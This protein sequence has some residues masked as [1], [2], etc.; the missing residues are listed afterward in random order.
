MKL[1]IQLE[2]FNGVKFD[3]IELEVQTTEDIK[4]AYEMLEGLRTKPSAMGQAQAFTTAKNNA[5]ATYASGKPVLSKDKKHLT[6]QE[7]AKAKQIFATT[8]RKIWEIDSSE[9]K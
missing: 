1:H 7:Y 9:L 3:F 4:K 2:P 5:L 8:Q 6:E